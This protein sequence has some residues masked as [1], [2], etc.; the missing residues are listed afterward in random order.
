MTTASK[1][2]QAKLNKPK[3]GQAH[4]VVVRALAGTGKTFTQIVGVGWAFGHD[5]E[6]IQEKI[7]D[8]KGMKPGTEIVPSE[9][10]R[11]I[12]S[13]MAE[14]KNPKSV[15][16]SAFNKS[17]VQEFTQ[18]WGWMN[19]C[20]NTELIFATVNSLGSRALYNVY[21]R[22][23]MDN[24]RVDTLIAE[25][26]LG[27][28]IW[29]ARKS[30]NEFLSV[31]RKLIDLAKLTLLGWERGEKYDPESIEDQELQRLCNHY[32]LFPEQPIRSYDCTRSIL[33]ECMKVDEYHQIDF[34][35]QNW[36][37]VIHNLSLVKHDLVL[38]DEAQDLPRCKQ[39]F[40]LKMSNRM[41]CVGDINQAIYGFAGADIHSIPRMEQ[42]LKVD[43]P[44]NLNQTRRCGKLIVA[45]C[46]K[47][48]PDFEVHEDNEDGE[49]VRTTIGKYIDLVEDGDLCL[50]R[51]NAPLV[52]Q[53]LRFLRL[54]RKAVIRGRAFGQSLIN[55][56]KKLKAED[57][58]DLLER[59]DDWAD[60][61]TSKEYRKKNPSDSKLVMISDRVD[62]I[63][64]FCEEFNEVEEVIDNINLVFNG[65]ECPECHKRF[66]EDT[67][68]CPICKTEPDPS[69]PR[70]Q[71]G[72]KLVLPQG[73]VFSS[74]HKAKGLESDNV[75]LLEPEGATVPHPMATTPWQ[76]K[77]ESN[78]RYVALSRSKKKLVY[79]GD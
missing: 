1:K 22:L 7:V 11:A 6:E 29:L 77:Q 64:V 13:A 42:L 3:K 50:C 15:L 39:E 79:V 26:F 49:V 9:Q 74:I 32:D 25:Q 53:A 54:G 36:L 24:N 34:N 55:F 56:I 71:T 52:S 76:K 33:S 4:N 73:V 48:V 44:L 63:R 12:W 69:N 5:W 19:D 61:E 30:E 17:I 31:T 20:L 8:R 2:L 59:L 68:R 60:K 14:T 66:N 10:Q 41:I 58:N 28:D 18:D 47:I 70:Y 27:K 37:P 75:F 23:S 35:D 16:Y 62:C 51:V 65:K 57:V 21:G 46:Q 38:V 67:A 45:E 43:E 78:L 40:L 72:P